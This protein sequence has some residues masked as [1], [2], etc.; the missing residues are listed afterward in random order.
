MVIMERKKGIL[1][2]TEK[3]NQNDNSQTFSN[4]DNNRNGNGRNRNRGNKK[5]NNR[6]GGTGGDEKTFTKTDD[7]EKKKHNKFHNR[8][9]LDNTG[10][11]YNQQFPVMSSPQTYTRDIQFFPNYQQPH[12]QPHPQEFYYAMPIPYQP[13]YYPGERP[14][15]QL[16]ECIT[17]KPSPLLFSLED[18][19]NKS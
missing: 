15:E 4:R 3:N 18:L 7:P 2:L 1:D 16:K 8:D 12:Q 6:G 9:Q 14:G 13:V 11:N 10:A 5:R 19:S 17:P